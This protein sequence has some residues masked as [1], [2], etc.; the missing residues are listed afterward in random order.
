LPSFAF[1]TF[2][3]HSR[4]CHDRVVERDDLHGAEAQLADL[5]VVAADGDPVVPPVRAL[6][7]GVDAGEQAADVVLQGEAHGQGHRAEQGHQVLRRR[8][9]EHADH[10][11]DG[12]HDDHE[13]GQRA[14]HR[15]RSPEAGAGPLGEKA[16]RPLDDDH[17]GGRRQYD[18]RDLKEQPRIEVAQH[19]SREGGFVLVHD[20]VRSAPSASSQN[21]SC[22]SARRTA[23]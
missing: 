4:L 19:A 3:V 9:D 2:S 16:R 21:P 8:L 15:E 7:Q 11:D 22:A 5:A 13:A 18:Q 10:G 14:G 6:D 17:G 20:Q 1:L 12:Q 23:G